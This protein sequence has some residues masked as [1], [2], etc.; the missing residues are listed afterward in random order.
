MKIGYKIG[1]EVKMAI[2]VLVCAVV[3]F[4]YLGRDRIEERMTEAFDGSGDSDGKRGPRGVMGPRGLQGEQGE[5]GDAGGEYQMLGR[6]GNVGCLETGTGGKSCYSEVDKLGGNVS[7]ASKGYGLNQV[8]QHLSDGGL[9][10]V[11]TGKCLNV[12]KNKGVGTDRIGMGTCG[13]SE[14]GDGTSWYYDGIARMIP[15][16]EDGWVLGSDKS[17]VMSLQKVK[18]GNAYQNWTFLG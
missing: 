3:L 8:W 14:D 9:K 2:V 5:K 4:V 18:S 7:L 17:G 10:N 1:T 13:T 11:G 15:K 16:G 6:L 12:V